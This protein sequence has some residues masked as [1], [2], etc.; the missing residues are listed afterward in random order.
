[1]GAAEDGNTDFYRP[2]TAGTEP[3]DAMD[4]ANDVYISQSIIP[5]WPGSLLGDVKYYQYYY[6]VFYK[7]VGS[8]GP[9]YSYRREADCQGQKVQETHLSSRA[10][11]VGEC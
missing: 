7:R 11:T 10:T 5:Q 9:R 4:D 6:A 1:M 8:S 2:E 3:Y